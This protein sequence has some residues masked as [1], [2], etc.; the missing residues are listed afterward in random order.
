[1]AHTANNPIIDG[2]NDLLA[3]EHKTC[4]KGLDPTRKDC[5]ECSL[6]NYNR[7]CHNQDVSFV[8]DFSDTFLSAIN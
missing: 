4:Q 7:N 6:C 3:V 5:R 8:S 2:L 1:M